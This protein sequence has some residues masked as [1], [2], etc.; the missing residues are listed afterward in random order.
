[1]KTKL[2]A[3][4]MDTAVAAGDSHC[5]TKVLG[6]IFLAINGQGHF[7]LD[8]RSPYKVMFNGKPRGEQALSIATRAAQT[9]SDISE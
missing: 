2:R 9:I 4:K 6:E 3:W 8:G 1:M 7:S 5:W